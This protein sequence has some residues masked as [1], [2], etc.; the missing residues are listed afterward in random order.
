MFKN[1]FILFFCGFFGISKAQLII[2]NTLT[3]TQLVQN[4]LVGQGVAPFN[5][6]FNRS[7]PAATA[8][9]DQASKF[10]T[11]FNPSGLGLDGG[12]LLTTG[13]SNVALGPNGAGNSSN[14]TAIPVTGDVDLAVLTGLSIENASILEFDFVATG[15][16]LNFD[17]VFASEEYPEY[18][19]S[20]FNDVFG[21]FLSGPG[22]TGTFSG[23]AANI[24][25][26]PTTTTGSSAVSIGN[27]NNGTTNTGPCRNCAYYVNNTIAA[28]PS[29]TYIQYDGFTVP[30]RAT[31]PLICGET[32]H[33]KLAIANVSD[34]AW[35]SGV[36]IKNFRI[37]PLVLL[38]NLGL[39][40][41]SAVCF[42]QVVTISSGVTPS[43]NIL[44]WYK[45]GVLLPLETSPDLVVTVDGVYTFEEY[46]PSGCRLAVDDI[47]IG[48]LPEITVTPPLDLTLCTSSPGPYQFNIDQTLLMT[49]TLTNPLDYIITYYNT[50]AGNEP[51]DG[52]PIGVIPDAD[53][54]TYL[55]NSSA[56]I[57]VR[58][59]EISSGCVLVKPFNLNIILPPSGTISF[60][61][62]PYCNNIIIPQTITE[63]S[64]TPGGV[65]SS[66][67][68]GLIIDPV[69]G[70]ITPFGSPL[71]IYTVNYDIAAT[72][73]C[74]AFNANTTVEIE[75]CPCTVIA[76]SSLETPCLNSLMNPISYT[77]T[78]GIT[79]IVLTAG[80]LPPG[81]SGNLVAGTYTISGT[82]TAVGIYIFTYEVTSG[83]VDVCD[84][85]TT[86][87]VKAQPDAGL[88][89]T[90]TVCD[91]STTAIDLF[92]LITGEQAG[93]VWTRT[94]SGTG[95]TFDATLGTFTPAVGASAI[96][97]FEYRITGVLP[98][99]DDFSTVTITINPQPIAGA[100]GSVTICN[101]DNTL[102]DLNL[103]ITGEQTGGVWTRTGTGTGGVFNA[104]AGTFVPSLTTTSSTF[105][106][107]LL[108]TLPCINDVSV[109]TVTIN[110]QPD[111]GADGSTLICDSNTAPIILST[112]ITG[113]QT[114]GVWTQLT[115]TGGVF[116]ATLGTFTPAVGVSL[117]N[118][119]EYR[120][121][122]VPPC[123]DDFSI[124]TIT[125]NPQPDAGIGGSTTV[126]DNDPTPI[127]LSLLIF[128]GQ[129]GGTWT[130]LTGSGGVFNAL[131]GTFTPA[132]GALTSTFKYELLGTLPCINSSSTVTV[133]INAQPY[134]GLDGSVVICDSNTTPINL[135]TLIT[136]EQ[137][138]GTWTQLTGTGG[139]FDAT[140]GTFTPA[141]AATTS[142]FEYKKLGTFPCIDD[143]S[144][145]TITIHPQ[146]NAGANGALTVCDNDATPINLFSLL[147]GAQA[148]GTWTRQFGSSGG[149]FNAATG[150]FIPTGATTSIFKYELLGTTPCIDDSSLVTIT[151]NSQPIA[152]ADG[153]VTI[154]DTDTTLIDLFTLITGEQPGG[155]WTR[156][157][158][159]GGVFNAL[160]GTFTPAALATPST[161]EYKLLGTFPCVDD[162][163]VATVTIHPQPDAGTA[164]PPLLICSDS[165]TTI[166]LYSLITGEQTGGFWTQ[167]T[168]T[169]GVFDAA[170]GTFTPAPGAT[171][172]TF[173]YKLLGTFPCLD[174]SS[175]VSIRIITASNAGV[176]GATTICDDSA[177]PVDLNT[178]ITSEQS[179]GV[180]SRSSGS[181][182][183]LTPAGIYTPASGAST[184]DFIYTI[185]GVAPCGNDTSVARVNINPQPN[186]GVDG[187]PKT[188]CENDTTSIDLFSLISGEQAGG[189]WVRST[190]TG[191]TFNALA[192]TFIPSLGSTTSTFTY[193]IVGIFPCVDDSSIAT[194]IINAQ[195][196]A[197][198]DASVAICDSST[199][200][201][202]LNLLIT[203][204]QIGGTWLRGTGTGGTFNAALGIFT[205]SVGA[206]TSTFTY[207]IPG[208]SPCTSDSSTAAVT[209]SPQPNAGIDGA[210]SICD[211][212][213]IPI[214]L[215]GLI[216]LEQAGGTWS[217]TTGT[218]GL[219]NAASGSFTP[220]SGSTT[221]SFT[222][223]IAG[224]FPC[225]D[226]SSLAT[227]NINNQP[228]A[229]F[230]GVA[231]II[232]ESATT[233]VDL[234][235]LITGE[236]PGGTWT[237]TTGVGGIFNA[238]AG[239]FIPT[240]GA[241]SSSFTYTL[242]GTAPCVND[243]SVG[244]VTILPTASIVLS[245]GVSTQT[246][247]INNSIIPI[248][249]TIG[250]GALGASITS[251]VLPLGVNPI[252][253]A[254]VLTISGTALESG[255]FPFV[256]TTSGGCSSS[257]LSGVLVVR[258]EVVLTLT[259]TPSTT[260]QSVCLNTPITPIT[261]RT[262]NNPTNVTVT[263]LP[264]GI[265]GLYQAGVMT[266][267][268][269]ASLVGSYPYVITTVGGCGVDSQ[270]GTITINPN[271][272]IT[273]L[274]PVATTSQRVCIN[275]PILPITYEV[276]NGATGAFLVAGTVPEGI[277][278]SFNPIS[279]TFTI[280]G[281]TQE[282]GVFNY[283]I[284]T[285]GGCSVATLTGT[286]RVDPLPVISLPQDGYICVDPSG[287][288]IVG[289]DY[290][291]TTNLSTSQ[292]SFV[293]SDING[294]IPGETGNSYTATTPGTYLVKVTSLTTNCYDI[295][296][297]TIA[298]SLAP[299][300][301]ITSVTS[302]FY[303]NQT[304]TVTV[305]PPGDYL[306]QLDSG[307]FQESNYFVGL[308][309]GT[310]TIT[311]KDKFAC[312]VVQT[313]FRIVNFPH[314]FTP[315]G[316]GYNDTW[317]IFEI[318]DQPDAL[319]SIF[320]RYGKLIKQISTQGA[321]W[322][323]TLNDAQ[324]PSNDYWFKVFYKENGESKEY[325]SHF[326]LK[327]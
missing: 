284:T 324:L 291:L 165:T 26:I 198:V 192:G 120:I 4:V 242:T 118:T 156:T 116:D 235:S 77:T 175:Q 178:L 187:L 310:H 123:V 115:G 203:G 287:N 111:A 208:V 273:L 137:T 296:N 29:F 180:W 6:K 70:A 94:G 231:Q 73:S 219:F 245:S 244:S 223:T 91:D 204:E 309:S 54:A 85:T 55:T 247:C 238:L 229:G 319:I 184:S 122:G 234:Y 147:T 298:P 317:N 17:Y 170:L 141:S 5:I 89:G 181:G 209:I 266:I 263:G 248:S 47:T 288:P 151:I 24:A 45:D 109:A 232:C 97:T 104:A 12:I 46:T 197:G 69:T 176:D 88:D 322:D 220:S 16:I 276:G 27:V 14:I 92:G 174:V 76:S 11:N 189:I 159:S 308:N 64:L 283:I 269:S 193:T 221:S 217:R 36:F 102:I 108:G 250:N 31:S 50:N 71:G 246:L 252:F 267:T 254:G 161:F 98:C 119:F 201:I 32:Y 297:A 149:V 107:T 59:E 264:V 196:N 63:T 215:F 96:C 144:V 20:A 251:G 25:V 237:R 34:S 316:D 206:T 140:L 136:G 236:Q 162:V 228:N 37:E 57:W 145:A 255:T 166:D 139:V 125:I 15:L 305:T 132:S 226:D 23:G 83:G 313:S 179:G 35:D 81:I 289:S 260:F 133:N 129:V 19:S 194:I 43:T 146:P 272:T 294:V 301:V 80:V 22:V 66:T 113:E 295:Q 225:V 307:L 41:N 200:A 153:G 99:V 168:G 78:A 326:S 253:S 1:I 142:T 100:D 318:A 3:P 299:A 84:V 327:R 282:S 13:R 82:P 292:Y 152:G 106:Y 124:V 315:N 281:V 167:L 271:V 112:L 277:Q 207:T 135:S 306:Y 258:P 224:V 51:Y 320:D 131:T 302:Y 300:T 74:P 150:T 2:D 243:S 90:A 65:Y 33:I 9:R 172:S 311:A 257:S 212:S 227:V 130:R 62:S 157:G 218:G 285:T 262:E 268:G 127:D 190:G 230:D 114:G 8:V 42:G 117:V 171:D 103:L 160:A 52:S 278:G 121:T 40:N 56:T 38:D 143:V 182:G 286:I 213:A 164:N 68:P 188:V 240:V 87:E 199:I 86:I 214:D 183:T 126:C 325:R 39:D 323:G 101:T 290:T 148:G 60:G 191:G 28:N 202:D 259:S 138:G 53:L 49:S 280:N 303:D 293:W 211:S 163:S 7:L 21:F 233:T 265:T 72:V 30:L 275:D 67:P 185:T 134:A 173:E 274:T 48:F 304:V 154:C 205:P 279:K 241:T 210:T 321:G 195:P 10:S 186:A 239:T 314:F 93:G 270:N 155:T 44:K 128:G 249:Y 105:E 256:V 95:G 169:G 61:A 312:G 222:Y 110:N 216:T 158:G 75:S 261:Y 79:G 177:I 58:I 18:T